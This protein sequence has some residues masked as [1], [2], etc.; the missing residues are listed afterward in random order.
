[1]KRS[2]SA[3]PQAGE[4]DF[5]EAE[6]S[7]S[8]CK[9][10]GA[11]R[12]KRPSANRTVFAQ[13]R[14]RPDEVLPEWQ[15]QQ[16]ALGTAADVQRFVQSACARLNAPLEGRAQTLALAA[17]A[18]ARSAAP[19]PGRRRHRANPLCS[20]STSCTAATRWSVCWL[21]TCWRP[22]W[23]G[24]SAGIAA[25]CAATLTDAVDVVT[26]CTCCAC[27]INWVMCAAASRSR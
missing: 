27:A 10:N 20:T 23:L 7:C 4:F 1:M 21:N 9:R 26:T 5:G 6:R 14:I 19:A 2:D 25:R 3:A 16:E 8:R 24:Q 22:A 17:A 12:W 11:M 13:R 15:K 18:P